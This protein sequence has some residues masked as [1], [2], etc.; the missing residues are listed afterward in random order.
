MGVAVTTIVAVGIGVLMA[1]VLVGG[2][3]GTLCWVKIGASTVGGSGG[4]PPARRVG[5]GG[6]AVG[7]NVGSGVRVPVGVIVGVLVIVGVFVGSA[8]GV[9][10]SK[11]T[12]ALSESVSYLR[13][14]K[15]KL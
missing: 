14:M 12:E 15:I 8:G 9:P 10:T 4:P 11:G 3:A 2:A 6:L 1:G 5:S 7:V 13:R